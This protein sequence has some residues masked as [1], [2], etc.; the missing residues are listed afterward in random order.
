MALWAN[1][2]R[3][4]PDFQS[5]VTPLSKAPALVAARLKDTEFAAGVVHLAGEILKHRFPLLGLTIETGPE[6]CWRRD[7]LNGRE[8]GLDYFRRVPYLD[9]AKAGDHKIIWEL[10]RH[11]HLVLLAQAFLFTDQDSYLTEIWSQLESWIDANPF[12]RGINWSSTLEVAFRALSWM[13]VDRKS[14]V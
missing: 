2:P 13:W 7:Y 14:V 8:T 11:Q 9:A 1:P 12:H 6:I 5:S 10:N 3:L 4:P